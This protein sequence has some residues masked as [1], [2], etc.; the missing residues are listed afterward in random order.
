[1]E[2]NHT[3]MPPAIVPNPE[4]NTTRVSAALVQADSGSFVIYLFDQRPTLDPE[5]EPVEPDPLYEI[6]RLAVAPSVLLALRNNIAEAV[7]LHESRYG[8][9]PTLPAEP[10]G[11]TAGS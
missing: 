8:A 11:S 9:I 2:N 10:A 6:G 4:L 3:P 5:G 1:M 7:A